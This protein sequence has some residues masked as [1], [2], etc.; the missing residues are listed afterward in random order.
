MNKLQACITW[1]LVLSAA[2]HADEPTTTLSTLRQAERFYNEHCLRCHDEAKAAGG[3]RIDELLAKP[4]IEGLEDPWMDVLEKLVSREMPPTDEVNRPDPA[5]FE[6][7]IAW[8]R[9]EL[10]SIPIAF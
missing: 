8:L 1:F 3:F 7:Q 5:D 6:K 4:T 10:D 2:I 9:G